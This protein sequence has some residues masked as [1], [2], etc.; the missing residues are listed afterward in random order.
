[1]KGR[2]RPETRPVLLTACSAASLSL[3]GACTDPKISVFLRGP[4]APGRSHF[5]EGSLLLVGFGLSGQ[6]NEFFGDA[7]VFFGCGHDVPMG[8]WM[9]TGRY[10]SRDVQA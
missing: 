7:A 9:C 8:H 6:T 2:A 10:S 1:M 5:Q 4:L 3:D